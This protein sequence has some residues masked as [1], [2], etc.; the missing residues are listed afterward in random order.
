VTSQRA[1]RLAL[2]LHARPFLAGRCDG[3]TVPIHRPVSRALHAGIA[4]RDR[5]GVSHARAVLPSLLAFVE[6][7]GFPAERVTTLTADW[8]DAPRAY[9]ARSTKL[10]LQR[11]RLAP[12]PD[13]PA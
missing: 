1:N 5:I 10:V 8:E 13:A 9:T 2:V 7:T 11:D 6:R 4:V 12:Q 3:D